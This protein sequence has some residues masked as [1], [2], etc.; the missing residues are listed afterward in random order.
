VENNTVCSISDVTVFSLTFSPLKMLVLLKEH[1]GVKITGNVKGTLTIN[2]EAMVGRGPAWVKENSQLI[3]H[4][5]RLSLYR[6]E[7]GG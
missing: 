5:L 3:N 6:F 2:L 1:S 7:G 4:W